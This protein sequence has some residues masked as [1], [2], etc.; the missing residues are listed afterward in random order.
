M[1]RKIIS[2]LAWFRSRLKDDWLRYGRCQIL[3][4]LRPGPNE[5]SP[6]PI[7]CRQGTGAE[8]IGQQKKPFEK[9]VE[10]DVAHTIL[11]LKTRRALSVTTDVREQPLRAAII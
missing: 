6:V 3:S 8:Q 5:P 2:E 4:R 10:Q 1:D 9:R 7:P 11:F